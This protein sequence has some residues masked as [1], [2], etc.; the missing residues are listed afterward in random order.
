MS[1]VAP[2]APAPHPAPLGPGGHAAP[3]PAHLRAAFA[4]VLD[5]MPNA[6]ARSNAPSDEAGQT[7]EETD[8]RETR[9]RPATATQALSASLASLLPGAAPPALSMQA[10]AEPQGESLAASA[11]VAGGEPSAAGEHAGLKGAAAPGGAPSV[12]KLVGERAFHAVDPTPWEAAASLAG[13]GRR[14]RESAPL[15][16][17]DAWPTLQATGAAPPAAAPS[18]SAGPAMLS[19]ATM[20]SPTPQTPSS[21]APKGLR[22]ERQSPTASAVGNAASHKP[23]P[24]PEPRSVAAADDHQPSGAEKAGAR[25]SAG[26]DPGQPQAQGASFGGPQ[27]ASLVAIGTAPAVAYASSAAAATAPTLSSPR[28]SPAAPTAPPVREIDVDLSPGGLED[29]SM[30]M[31]LAGD[32]LSLVVRAASS[33]TTGAIEGAREAIAER[34]AAIGQPLSAFIIQQTGS[35]VDANAREASN[36]EGGDARPQSEQDLGSDGRGARRGDRDF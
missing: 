31:R 26:A 4:A 25:D 21:A 20:P 32:K 22:A 5:S 35:S 19:M 33:Q 27:P 28:A 3:A 30:T 36:R 29:V 11:P 15:P 17:P 12:G 10:S 8:R 1:A 6:D 2:A 7:L 16:A 18:A 13:A 9:Q 23:T 24:A 14:P 34:L